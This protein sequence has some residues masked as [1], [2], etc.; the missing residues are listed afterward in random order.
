MIIREHYMT[1]GDGINLYRN[2]SDAGMMIRQEQTGHEYSEAVDLENAPYT[3]TETNIPVPAPDAPD[4]LEQAAQ[5]LLGQ[6][7]VEIPA[8]EEPDYLNENEPEP[9]YFA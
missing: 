5:Y 4:N 7:L 9:D 1:R 2:Y 8:E 6:N 3:Y